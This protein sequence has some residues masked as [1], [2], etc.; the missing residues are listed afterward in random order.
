MKTHTT[1]LLIPILGL[2]LITLAG[3]RA[4][5]EGNTISTNASSTYSAF[6]GGSCGGGWKHHNGEF[7]NLTD[8]ERQELKAAME[9]IKGNPQL[10]SARESVKQA[11]DNLRKTRN[12]LLLQAD[13][14][15]QPILDKLQS[16]APKG[17]GSDP[18][19]EPTT[20]PE[21]N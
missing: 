1:R 14:N 13:P 3:L 11:L 8:T 20:N 21:T 4:Q 16:H 15:I 12:Q 5:D 17:P 2:G 7:A 9:Q 6:S 18:G 10:Q 19:S